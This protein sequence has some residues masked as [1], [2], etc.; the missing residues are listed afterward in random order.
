MDPLRFGLN[1]PALPG[2][3]G[4]ATAVIDDMVHARWGDV[5]ARFDPTMREG[6]ADD[7]LAA[8]WAHIVREAGAYRGR[9]DTDAVR[10][11]DFTTTNTPL[12]FE[13]G[14]FVARIA[15][16]DDQTI[17]GLFILNPDAARRM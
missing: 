13:A 9:G 16:R 17:A 12:A 3:T 14:E 8:G 1:T 6:L 2:A 5:S 10:T 15:F 4:L 7:E 11:G